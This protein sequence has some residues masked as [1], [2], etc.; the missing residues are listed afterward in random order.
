MTRYAFRWVAPL[1][2]LGASYVALPRVASAQYFG[3]NK[4][5][6]EKFDF[7][8]MR[9][10][11]FDLY[12]YPAESLVTHDA[13]RLA[14]RWYARHSDS[15]RHTFDRKSVI[16]YADQPDFQQTNVVGEELTESTGG[17]T[18]GLRTRVVMPFTG[19]YADNDHVL[20]HELVHVF[21]YSVAESGPGGL[22]RLNQL[23]LWLIEG[24]AEYFSLGRDN[25]LTAMWLRDAAQRDRLPT[26]HQLTTDPRFFPYRYGQAL[27]AYVGGRWGDRSIVDVYKMSLRV[28]FEEGIRRVL[29]VSTD[30][31]SKDWIAATRRA[32]LPVIEGK[33]GP[34]D[35]GDPILQTSRKTGD[36]NLAPTVSPDGKMVAFFARRGLF[37]IEL[38][39]ADAQTGHVIKKLAGPTSNSHFD[40]ITFISSSGAWSP[41]S[42]KFAFIAQVEGN[43]EIAI[44]DVASANIEQR[45]RVP[46]V[47]A[48]SNIAWSPD[49]KTIAFSGQHGG[50]SDLYLIDRTAGTVRQLTND[51]YADIQPTWSPDGQTIAFATDRGAQTDFTTMSFS[52]L[53]L[54]TID[55]ATGRISVFSPFPRGKHINPQY[56]PDGRSLFF[57]SDQDGFNDIYRLQLATGAVTRVTRLSTGVSGITDISPAMSVAPSTGRMLFSV[58][59]DQ[60]YAVFA[61]DSTR[62]RGEPVVLGAAVASASVLPPG[63]TPGRSTVSQYLHDPLTGLPPADIQFAVLPYHSSFS[64]DAIGQPSLGV[65]AGGPFGTGVAGGVSFLFGDQLSDKQIGVGIQANG[66]VQDIGGQ[67]IYQ[68]LR[69]RWNYGASVEHIPYLTGFITQSVDPTTGVVQQDLVL[70]RIFLDQASL[71]TAYP[72]SM[73]RRIEFGVAAT[74]IGFSTEVQSTFF[75][76]G[77]TGTQVTSLPSPPSINYGQGSI[78][79]VGDNS[80]SAFTN[81]IQGTRY[82]FELSPTFP[83]GPRDRSLVYT[84]ALADYRTYFFARPFTL[85]F[86]GLH[87]GRYGRDGDDSTRMYPLFLGEE[88]IMRGY[89]YGSIT[90]EE[91]AAS[92][93]PTSRST[94]PVFDRMLGSRVGVVSAEFRIP[95]FGVPEYGLINFPYLPLT[96]APFVDAGEAWTG[97]DPPRLSFARDQ[98]RGVVASAG[99]SA[100][101]NLFGYAI[102]EVYGAHPFQ[103]PTKSWVYGVQLAPGW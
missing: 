77:G 68:N 100:R 21:Q 3:R 53:Q 27:W 103:R 73:T 31:L 45:L 65:S 66:Q 69:N 102:F 24:M 98:L 55:V 70:Q 16:F 41:S 86:R 2:L 5:Q 20:G 42:D 62:T 33:T 83:I 89:G 90:A 10:P 6:Y 96:V 50:I 39:V 38:F 75:G 101:F 11:H 9:T 13:G 49:G 46:G 79:Y 37:E 17:V 67:V 34:R 82:R 88:T 93:I 85:A 56:S 87:Y 71:N 54:G 7:H 78:A 94:C 57:I 29:G 84:A 36:M 51:R 8:I 92:Q 35:A 48:I 14:E 4:V 80:Y 23:P 63:D 59:E 26:I 19:I 1:V 44:L 64:L 61:L 43:H 72:F 74:H 32:Y 22:A 25:S 52:P 60:G 18:E 91:C 58:F 76:G 99:V 40:A 81:P 95:V 28:G 30:S 47:G 15:F 97:A 12:F